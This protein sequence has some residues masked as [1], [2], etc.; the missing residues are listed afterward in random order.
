MK[1]LISET[2]ES[3]FQKPESISRKM[4]SFDGV[5]EFRNGANLRNP[6]PRN[7]PSK[8]SSTSASN[9]PSKQKTGTAQV[10][11]AGF[12]VHKLHYFTASSFSRASMRSATTSSLSP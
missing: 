10:S 6:R 8:M 9:L 3:V 4:E 7:H 5:K 11:S 12:I 2:R 1:G